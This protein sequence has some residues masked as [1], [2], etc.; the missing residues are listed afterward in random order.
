MKISELKAGATLDALV[1]LAQPDL[2][3]G[4]DWKQD[5]YIILGGFG[6]TPPIKYDP[7]SGN[8]QTY[9]LIEKFGV[10]VSPESHGKWCAEYYGDGHVNPVEYWGSTSAE[11]ICKAVIASKWGDTIPDEIW[12]KAK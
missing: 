9:E 3:L 11:A 2:Q 7:S 1:A 6:G 12:E 8:A 4:D 10:A 5:G